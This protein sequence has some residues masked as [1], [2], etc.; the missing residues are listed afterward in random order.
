MAR[1]TAP[2]SPGKYRKKSLKTVIVAILAI[3]VLGMGTVAAVTI[4]SS[5]A[6]TNVMF[7]GLGS[8][9][10]HAAFLIKINQ[11]YLNFSQPQYQVKSQF[12]H[13][14]NGVGTTLHKHAS[15]VPVGEFLKSIHMGVT[16]GCFIMDDGQQYC[17]D[18]G[19]T[20]KFFVNGQ[21]RP[22]SSIMSYI[23]ND[24][25]HFIVIYG[26]ESDSELGQ[27]LSMLERIP[28]IKT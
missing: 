6:K 1:K 10:E 27:E 4:N 11:N 9:H 19:K 17:K 22:V 26:D 12:I 24:G 7:G 13:V 5:P 14:E 15:E 21:E 18:G 20:L 28:I 8:A 16:N 23:L 3:A 25:D 2:S